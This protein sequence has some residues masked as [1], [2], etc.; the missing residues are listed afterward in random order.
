MNAKILISACILL[1]LTACFP[2]PPLPPTPV[3]P[4]D[5]PSLIKLLHNPDD[6]IRLAAIDALGELG[7]AAAPAVPDLAGILSEDSD[8]RMSAIDTLSNIGPAAAPAVPA[9]IKVLDDK[10]SGYRGQA[11]QALGNIGPEAKAAIPKL[12]ERLLGDNEATV[13]LSSA[14]ALGNIGDPEAIPSLI[15][16]LNDQDPITRRYVALAL[17][18]FGKQARMAVPALVAKLSDEEKYVGAAAGFAI[19]KITGENFPDSNLEGGYSTE[20]GQPRI[21]KAAKE[22]WD[23]YGKNQNWDAPSP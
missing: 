5:I 17:A 16:A 19:A 18:Q 8:L 20:N 21:V 23:T 9:L 3:V 2:S 10:S 1:S 15:A 11:A 14:E 4:R 6:R 7:P 13:R 22:W 12:E